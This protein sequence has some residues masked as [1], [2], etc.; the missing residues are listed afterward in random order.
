MQTPSFLLYF[1]TLKD[2]RQPWK[3]DD[4]LN[5]ILLLLLSATIAG[6]EGFQDITDYGNT[7]LP[8][9]RQYLPYTNGIPSWHTLKRVIES[10]E[11]KTF[12]TCLIDWMS[13]LQTELAQHIAIDEKCLRHSF[14]TQ[15]KPIHLVSAWGS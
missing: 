3:I 15:S 13:S 6:S 12:R 5:E 9:L 4:P 2:P 14:S 10:L 8:F 1:K 11:P 7:K